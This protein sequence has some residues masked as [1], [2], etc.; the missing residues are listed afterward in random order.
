MANLPE[1]SDWEDS[2]YQ[3]E[4]T[5]PVLGSSGGIANLQATQLGNRTT[6]LKGQMNCCCIYFDWLQ[7]CSTE[8]RNP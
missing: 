1:T 4:P 2:I 8:E 7:N 3:L 6:Y 5:N